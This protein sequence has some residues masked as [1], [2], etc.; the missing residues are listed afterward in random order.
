[1]RE[2]LWIVSNICFCQ[3]LNTYRAFTSHQIFNECLNLLNI[4]QSFIQKEAIFVVFNLV[5]LNIDGVHKRL[6][7]EED[8]FYRLILAIYHLTSIPNVI[9]LI[10]VLEVILVDERKRGE[11][12]YYKLF[13]DMDGFDAIEQLQTH[14]NPMLSQCAQDM[15]INLGG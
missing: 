4:K 9:K 11:L 6:V 12:A 2:G 15:L 10:K 5:K 13:Q 8:L 7:E 1:M 3:D 14:P